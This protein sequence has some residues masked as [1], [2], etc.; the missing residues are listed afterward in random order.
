MSAGLLLIRLVFGV[1]MAAHGTQKLFGWLGGYGIAG[2]GQFFEGIGFR[3]G[4]TFAA[5][6]GLAESV[7]GVLLLLGLVQPLAAILII[8]V[9]TTAIGSVHLGRGWSAT[10]NGPEV[11]ILYATAAATLT[12]TGP[13]TYSGDAV[14]GLLPLWS[15]TVKLAAIAIGIVGGFMN[16]AIRRPAAQPA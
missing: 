11:P 16:L 5:V 12:L 4:S 1:L 14:L 15:P 8:S 2:T 9:M 10:T 3:P 6:A 7:G 13:G